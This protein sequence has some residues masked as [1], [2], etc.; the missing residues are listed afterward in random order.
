MV[1]S[2]LNGDRSAGG[3]DTACQSH[4]R[5]LIDDNPQ[6]H[7]FHIVAFRPHSD[8]TKEGEF[9]QISD[10]V[11]LVFYNWNK[12]VPGT[13]PHLPG[14]LSR[15]I[16]VRKEILKFKPDFVHS[17]LPETP[18]FKWEKFKKILTLHSWKKI[19]RSNH[20]ILNNI[21]YERILQP[22]SL[23]SADHI[24][25][26][27]RE[28][29]AYIKQKGGSKSTPATLVYN[30]ISDHHF[31]SKPQSAT[32]HNNPAV[33]V[34]GAINPKKRIIDCVVAFSKVLVDVPDAELKFAGAFNSNDEYFKE[35]IER[36]AQLGIQ[37]KV[38]FMGVLK[39]HDLMS[40]ID[41][42]WVG[43]SMSEQ[44][45]F[46][47]APLEILARNTPVVVSKVGIFDAD[48]ELLETIGAVILEVGDVD[49]AA[50]ALV[51]ALRGKCPRVNPD[52]LRDSYSTSRMLEAFQEIYDQEFEKRTASIRSGIIQ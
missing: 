20:G 47:L 3:L 29:L 51:D 43:L 35:T 25:S 30:T 14:F 34:S 27:S 45:T 4:L 8:L 48:K 15:E 22:I 32:K 46:G 2:S 42:A 23:Q 12:S 31:L 13:L 38:T 50:Q 17:H 9:H 16:A 52:V 1:I 7:E 37:E 40:E 44:E 26:V 36:V 33:L 5:G 28:I 21:L 18:L 10:N 19:G 24:T 6:N 39:H 11:S 41:Q 49:A